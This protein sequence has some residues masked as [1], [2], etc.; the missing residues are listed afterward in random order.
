LEKETAGGKQAKGGLPLEPIRAAAIRFTDAA[1]RLNE[2]TEDASV[3][4]ILA[5]GKL[6]E[7]NQ[8]LLRVERSFL[9]E[10]GLPG[11]DWFR[12]AF[13]APG[14]YTGYAVVVMPG[15]REA[16]ERNDDKAAAEQL[17]QVRAAINRGTQALDRALAVV[18]EGPTAKGHIERP[19]AE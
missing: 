19:D 12:H 2:K 16:L 6:S 14:V 9:L 17:E 3:K 15:V 18:G 10:P 8:A 4:G 11:R 13:Y 1:H 5:A 7:L